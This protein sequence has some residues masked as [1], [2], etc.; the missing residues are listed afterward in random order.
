MSRPDFCTL[1]MFIVDE[2]YYR[3]PRLPDI[4]VM[5]G[6]GLY[7]ALGARLFRP[8]PSSFEVGWVVHKGCDFSNEMESTLKSWGTDCCFIETPNRN[9]T[10]GLNVYEAN[11]RR[12]SQVLLLNTSR[13]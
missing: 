12:G 6:G 11:G 8:P 4:S 10:R 3:P 1:G 13:R 7:A 2:I 9:T 5:G